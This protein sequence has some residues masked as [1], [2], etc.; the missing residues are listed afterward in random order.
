M[1]RSIL[2]CTAAGAFCLLI[3]CGKSSPS[4]PTSTQVSTSGTGTTLKAG[5]PNAVSPTG[6]VQVGT[7]VLVASTTTATYENVPLSYHFQVRSG[8][9]VIA[10]G[11]VGPVSGSQVSYT[12]TGL[13]ANTNYTWRVQATYG[14]NGGAWSSDASFK[15]IGKFNDGNQILDPMTDGTTVGIQHGGQF[16]PGQGWQSTSLS[17]SIDYPI[18]TCASCTFEFD[19]QGFGEQE[20]APYGLDV[21]WVSMGDGSTF[22]D[23]GAFRDSPWKMTMEER[24]DNP[25]GV[26]IVWRNGGNDSPDPDHTFKASTGIAWSSSHQPPYH[27]VLA[28]TP[29]GFSITV[30]GQLIDSAP[31]NSGPYTPPNMTLELGCR[32]RGETMIGAIWSNVKLTRN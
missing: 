21:K 2:L 31:F 17:D 8:S 13:A 23:F 1:S 15:T 29:G 22:G 28:W 11:T 30:D 25:T 14:G 6:G 12:P 16:V 18:N 5:T 10:D 27:F 4:S 9:T 32:P 26:K 19:V 24:G 3:A 7:P 20:G